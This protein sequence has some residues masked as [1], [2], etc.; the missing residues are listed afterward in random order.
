MQKRKD[1]PGV[2]I[3]LDRPRFIR[4]DFNAFAHIQAMGIELSDASLLKEKPMLTI[5]NVLW[6]GLVGD[7]EELTK[8]DVGSWLREYGLQNALTKI[9]EAFELAQPKAKDIDPLPQPAPAQ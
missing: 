7:D 2:E 5:R 4:M 8:A 9:E 3:V 1:A 6:A